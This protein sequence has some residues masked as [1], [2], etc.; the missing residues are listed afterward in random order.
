MEP[1]L[2]LAGAKS[3]KEEEPSPDTITLI[4]LPEGCY[5]L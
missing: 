3:S 1:F 4:R 2:G 5:P